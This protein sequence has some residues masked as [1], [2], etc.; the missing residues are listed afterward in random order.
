M[1]VQLSGKVI[2]F[3]AKV[4][5][6]KIREKYEQYIINVPAGVGRAFRGYAVNLHDV[7]IIDGNMIHYIPKLRANTVRSGENVSYR[8]YIPVWLGRELSDKE[9]VFIAVVD[10]E[11]GTS[12]TVPTSKIYAAVIVDEV[13][14]AAYRKYYAMF[15]I[16]SKY[17]NV[18]LQTDV[19]VDIVTPDGILTTSGR[20][21]VYSKTGDKT[22]YA[23]RLN[24]AKVRE[25]IGR[26]VVS[27]T[28]VPLS[29]RTDLLTVTEGA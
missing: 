12:A 26:K 22:F 7:R 10:G 20:T 16:P 24:D 19:E 29:I 25:L 21:F 13:R 27:V 23:V 6:A 2:A 4:F 9:I 17:S 28:K 8:I 3:K 5:S 11:D 1:K 18:P 14:I 15:I